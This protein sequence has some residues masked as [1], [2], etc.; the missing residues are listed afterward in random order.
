[1]HMSDIVHVWFVVCT[2]DHPETGEEWG[3]AMYCAMPDPEPPHCGSIAYM[4]KS[5]DAEIREKLG[6]LY[7]AR[8]LNWTAYGT[9]YDPERDNE[10]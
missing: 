7:D 9:R 2:F 4:V 6:M 8:V 3:A 5:M 10:D 1:M